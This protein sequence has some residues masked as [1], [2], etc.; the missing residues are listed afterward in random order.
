MK[1]A[2][3]PEEISSHEKDQRRRS[4]VSGKQCDCGIRGQAGVAGSRLHPTGGLLNEAVLI[5]SENRDIDS[6][7]F[8]PS[9]EYQQ[10]SLNQG[11][12]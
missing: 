11:V 1:F 7:L 4:I 12:F 8:I 9:A 3:K 5:S 10:S 6:A 2:S